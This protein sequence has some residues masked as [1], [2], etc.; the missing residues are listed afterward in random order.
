MYLSTIGRKDLPADPQDPA[1][2][3][4]WKA[5]GGNVLALGT[6]SLVTDVSAE[7]VTAVLPLYLVL[8]LH[9]SPAAYGALDGLHTGA[10]ALLRLVGGYVADR[11]R[12]RKAVAGVGYGLSA[13][14]KLGL[15]AAGG[16]LASIGLVVAADRAG[17]GLRTAPRDALI[18][19]SAPEA[20]L[21]RAFGVHRAMDSVGAFAGP[22]VALAVLTAAG[23]SF[24]AVFVTS[25][26]V[27]ALG[28]L[29]LFLFVRDHREARPPSGT[30]SPRAVGRLL[31]TAPV[32][33]LVCAACLL[34][35]ATVGDG[36]VYLLLQ[37]RESLSIGWFPLLAVGTSLSYLLLAAPIGALADRIGRLPVMLGGYGVLA[38]VYL[39]LHGPL[40]GPV[41]LGTVLF[42]YGLFYAA[43]EGVLLA[44]AGPV[45]PERLRTTGIALVQSGQ[46]LAYLASSVLFGLAWQEWGGAAAS[47]W[48]AVAVVGVGVAT[49]F[50]LR[51]SSPRS[52]DDQ[53]GS[54]S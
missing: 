21:G 52:T 50:L 40:D 26:C 22:L 17:K 37:R 11:V 13:F 45:L 41:L 38:A 18:T 42:L 48:A 54:P 47:R 44:L 25:F 12:R 28:L 1:R 23:Q 6:V 16:S 14:A 20:S 7:M 24:D 30:V 19:L 35:L 4:R 34:G 46:A 3:G 8:G 32:R 49:A 15:V 36:F 10:T 43:T 33:R 2:R 9:L 31:R 53:K 5:V 51:S 27:A 29:I 39:L